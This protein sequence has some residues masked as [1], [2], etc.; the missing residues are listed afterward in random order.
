LDCAKHRTKK[1]KAPE[2]LS[3]N[4]DK[5]RKNFAEKSQKNRSNRLKTLENKS[6]QNV[7]SVK[8]FKTFQRL[9]T[10]KN[11]CKA[12]KKAPEKTARHLAGRK[13]DFLIKKMTF[14]SQKMQKRSGKSAQKS[15]EKQ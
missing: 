14:T 9:K 2:K 6:G 10:E 3:R 8:I 13:T 4:R 11:H 12:V 1:K 5:K 7:R 15:P